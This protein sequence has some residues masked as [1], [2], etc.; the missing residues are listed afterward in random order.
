MRS[1]PTLIGLAVV[2]VFVYFLITVSNR[3]FMCIGES[4]N[5]A[6]ETLSR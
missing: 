6:E 2:L 3:C 4:Q 5:L 1:F